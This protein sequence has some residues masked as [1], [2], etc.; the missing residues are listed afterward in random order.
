MADFTLQ[1]GVL[2]SEPKRGG[3]AGEPCPPVA[4]QGR[5]EANPCHQGG[6][7]CNVD[8]AAAWQQALRELRDPLFDLAKRLPSTQAALALEITVWTQKTNALLA[9]VDKAN[10]AWVGFI[11]ND[12]VRRI[13]AQYSGGCLLWSRA[14]QA[15]P[16][17][18]PLPTPFGSWRDAAAKAA[19]NADLIRYAI[20][21]V[22]G[23]AVFAAGS[24][25]YNQVKPRGATP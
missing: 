4:P 23:L 9:E 18:E 14:R 22:I 25:I 1:T 17:I 24:Y 10:S 16:T 3:N 5:T 19:N 8:D 2:Q 21:G 11:R 6:L 15:D 13:M 7:Y 20:I 12:E